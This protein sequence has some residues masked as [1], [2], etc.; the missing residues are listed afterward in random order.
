MT[1]S[2]RRVAFVAIGGAIGATLRWLI[3]EELFTID[4]SFPWAILF[5]NVAGSAALGVTLVEARRRP[6]RESLLIDG[7][8]T[9]FCG[10][11]TTFSAFAVDT[12]TLSRAG[13]T[14]TAAA[15]VAVTL[16]LGIGAAAIAVTAMR[17]AGAGT[18]P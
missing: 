10:G 12:A 1:L 18:P 13:D 3:A 11:L 7:I 16:V 14:G 4:G 8:G 2:P 6:D 17:R 15:Y 9:G 5:V